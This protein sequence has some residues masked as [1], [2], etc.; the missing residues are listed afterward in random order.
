MIMSTSGRVGGQHIVL[1]VYASLPTSMSH[2]LLTPIEPLLKFFWEACFCSIE[3][4]LLI[5]AMTLTFALKVK[6]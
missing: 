1:M 6:L 5:F 3:H 2:Q 4:W